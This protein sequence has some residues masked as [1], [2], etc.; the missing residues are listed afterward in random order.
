MKDIDLD[1]TVFPDAATLQEDENGGRINV[2]TSMGDT[3]GDGDFD[4]IYTYGAR[5]FSIWNTSGSLIYDSGDEFEQT[6]AMEEED[7]F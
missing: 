2:T 1:S 4:E 5:S 6:I 7:N 3:D